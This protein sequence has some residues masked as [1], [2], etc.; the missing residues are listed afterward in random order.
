MLL[1]KSGGGGLPNEFQQVEYVQGD[2]N[3]YLDLGLYL[4][5]DDEIFADVE[6]TAKVKLPMGIYGSR[7]SSSSEGILANFEEGAGGRF[8]VDR[9]QTSGASYRVI[10]AALRGR[11]Y[12]IIN[13]R[14]ER[15]V[16]N[17]DASIVG[18][19]QTFNN[20][21]FTTDYTCYLFHANHSWTSAKFNGKIFSFVVTDKVN[22]IPCYRKADGEIGMYDIVNNEFHTNIGTGTFIKGGDV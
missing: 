8:V 3:A 5:S 6:I 18:T 16:L 22:L 19:N 14:N 15:T 1:K 9:F 7:T 20:E 10:Q 21:N 13:T 11:R 2:G 12:T 4:D 17:D